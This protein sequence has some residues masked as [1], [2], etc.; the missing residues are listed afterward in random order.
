MGSQASDLACWAEMRRARPLFGR[1]RRARPRDAQTTPSVSL[2]AQLCR[3]RAVSGQRY[4]DGR[5]SGS[6]SSIE[7]THSNRSASVI[8][9]SSKSSL[10]I[11]CWSSDRQQA[12]REGAPREI[13]RL[14]GDAPSSPSPSLSSRSMR[15]ILGIALSKPR[16]QCVARE[17]PPTRRGSRSPCFLAHL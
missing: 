7:A 1:P 5:S 10:V 17:A 16:N 4:A 11:V 9:E 6:R 14:S 8:A 15:S 13:R 12:S 3:L 2:E